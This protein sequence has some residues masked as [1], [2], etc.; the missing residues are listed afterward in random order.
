MQQK[1]HEVLLIFFLPNVVVI[2][3]ALDERTGC[4]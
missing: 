2:V 3:H 4:S 1:E